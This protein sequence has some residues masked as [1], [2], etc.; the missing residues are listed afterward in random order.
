MSTSSTKLPSLIDET[1]HVQAPTKSGASAQAQVLKAGK[2]HFKLAFAIVCLAAAG[3][4]MAMT[5]LGGGKSLAELT[6]YT[7]CIDGETGEAFPQY[8]VASG[9]VKPYPNPRTG[10]R[11][12]W[13][14]ETCNWTKDGKAK[15]EPTYILMNEFVGKEGPTICPDCGRKV[16]FRNPSPPIELMEQAAGAGSSGE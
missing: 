5:L 11:T 10:K 4:I 7:A 16:V 12:I 15:L 3:V 13:P 9:D 1:E 14:A 6:R 8:E 2:E